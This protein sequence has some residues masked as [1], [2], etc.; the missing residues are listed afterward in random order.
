[1]CVEQRENLYASMF[2]D[3]MIRMVGC[4][5]MFMEKIYVWTFKSGFRVFVLFSC[6]SFVCECSNK[7]FVRVNR[8]LVLD[9]HLIWAE[10]RPIKC[11]VKL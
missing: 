7:R 6:F 5:V 9:A 8:E 10:I 1:M 11:N 3:E 4:I 2:S